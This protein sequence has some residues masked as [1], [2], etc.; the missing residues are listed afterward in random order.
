MEPS[1]L[2]QMSPVHPLISHFFSFTLQIFYQS[3]VAGTLFLTLVCWGGGW[4]LLGQQ[5]QQAVKEDQLGN[6]VWTEQCGGS[7]REDGKAQ[8][9]SH[10]R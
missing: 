7:G 6:Q 8:N 1:S 5:F 10:L 4:R 9:Q 3:V 2:T